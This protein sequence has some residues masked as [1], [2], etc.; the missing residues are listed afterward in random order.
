MKNR[1]KGKEINLGDGEIV[2]GH[3]VDKR[4]EMYKK[5][6]QQVLKDLEENKQ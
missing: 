1:Y 5:I 2:E 4:L 6:K 3:E